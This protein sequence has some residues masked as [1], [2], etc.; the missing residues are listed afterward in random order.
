MGGRPRNF[1]WVHMSEDKVRTKDS[2]CSVGTIYNPS[3]LSRVSTA[4][5][6][7]RRGVT[8]TC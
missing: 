3:E 8:T 2:R 4:S 7:I 6:G 5:A 1:S